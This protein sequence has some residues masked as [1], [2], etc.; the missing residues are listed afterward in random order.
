MTD[1]ERRVLDLLPWLLYRGCDVY[2]ELEQ[3]LRDLQDMERAERQQ[4]RKAA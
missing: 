4:E 1:I 3:V 2:G